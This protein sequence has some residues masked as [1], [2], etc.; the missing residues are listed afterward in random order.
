MF[1]HRSCHLCAD[2]RSDVDVGTELYTLSVLLYVV[3]DVVDIF[4][5]RLVVERAVPGEIVELRSVG[6]HT[7]FDQW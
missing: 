1:A 2:G 6:S 5:C 3:H 4:S 7:G